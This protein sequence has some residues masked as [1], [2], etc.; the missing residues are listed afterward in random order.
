M[1]EVKIKIRFNV[2]FNFMEQN[3]C[4][5]NSQIPVSCGTIS[6]INTFRRFCHKTISW[7][8]HIVSTSSHCI[9]L[10]HL[11]T[12]LSQLCLD[13]PGDLFTWGFMATFFYVFLFS[14][15]VLDSSVSIAISWMASVRF[16]AGK[17]FSQLHSI[18]TSS[19]AHLC[20]WYWGCSWG[21]VAG[22]WSRPLTS[23]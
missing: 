8:K 5:S 1:S 9:S 15:G 10:R 7:A 21:K 6:C 16:P 18:Q 23:I 14:V 3:S 12:F 11:W 2:F 17:D 13:L 19:E 22:P 4:M 20:N